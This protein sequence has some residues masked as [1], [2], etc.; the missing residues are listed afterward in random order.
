MRNYAKYLCKRGRLGH[1]VNL[2]QFDT[3]KPE[4]PP[5]IFITSPDPSNAHHPTNGSNNTILQDMLGRS[6]LTVQTQNLTRSELNPH[7]S[8]PN[9]SLGLSYSPTSIISDDESNSLYSPHT[10]RHL[11]SHQG[12]ITDT[13]D[14]P[15]P[16]PSANHQHDQPFN[17]VHSLDT[18][19][20]R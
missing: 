18:L 20:H 11:S 5:S 2:E 13:V 3:S 6:P 16:Q 14:P 7:G 4:R 17:F 1:Y 19:S 9:S 12:R 8:R 15:T 10:P